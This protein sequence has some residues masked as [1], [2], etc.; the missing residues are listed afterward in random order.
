MMIKVVLT[1]D[2]TLGTVPTQ[3]SYSHTIGTQYSTSVSEEMSISEGIEATMESN[4]L[5]I[6][7][8]GL[9]YSHTTGYNWGQESSEA[10]SKQVTT[11]VDTTV[12]AGII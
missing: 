6:M 1:C 2:N 9:K 5:D 7:S 12:P 11:T 10:K 4:F 8:A 3:C